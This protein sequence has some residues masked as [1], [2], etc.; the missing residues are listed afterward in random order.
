MEV[1]AA[2][3]Y[4][5]SPMRLRG[6]Q[7]R[8]GA[9]MVGVLLLASL[10]VG[11]LASSGIASTIATHT[12]HLVCRIAGGDCKAAE[13]PESQPG[14]EGGDEPSGPILTDQPLPVLPF[15]G[16]VSVSCTYSE[17]STEACQ[18]PDQPGVSVQATGELSIERTPTSLNEDGCPQQTLSVTG[19]LEL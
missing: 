2:C 11:A 16:S 6:E 15:P 3:A 10:I 17:T 8:T 5:R 12:A 19:K 13:P 4:R 9:E 18:P 7:G 14:E 1:A